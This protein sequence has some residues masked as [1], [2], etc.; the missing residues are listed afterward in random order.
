MD[1]SGCGKPVGDMFVEGGL[2]PKRVSITNGNDVSQ[3]NGDSWGVPKSYLISNME[4]RI[5]SAE[6]KVAKALLESGPLR[7][8][9]LDFERH[10][11]DSGRTTWGARVGKHDDIVLACSLAVWWAVRTARPDWSVGPIPWLDPAALWIDGE[12]I[13]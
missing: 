6:L 9:L 5:H 7:E 2:R 12:H 13:G 10:V 8:E 4:S 3:L 11:T 1:D